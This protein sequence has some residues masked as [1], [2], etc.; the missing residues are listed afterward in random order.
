MDSHAQVVIIGAGIVGCS[1]AY[2]LSQLGCTD[3]VVVDKGPLF[4]TGG[5]STHAPGLVFQTNPSQTM[6]EL[7]RY[8]VERYGAATLDGQPCFHA[9]GGIEVAAT[10]ERWA[11]LKRKRGLASSWGV[12]SE[13]L[14]PQQVA[15][16]VPLV[17]RERIYGGFHVPGDG[18]AKPVRAA[19]AMARDAQALGVRFH[20]QVEVSG[21]DI[22][23]ERI[24]AVETDQ[25]RISCEAVV[26]CAGIWG[27]RIGRLAGVSIPVQP[28]AHQYAWTTDV[29]GLEDA[30]SEVTHP[31]L[32]HQDRAMY[33]R[34][35]QHRYGVGSYQHRSIPVSVDDIR[36]HHDSDVM[37]SVQAFTSDD[38]KRPW[39]DAQELL[40]ALT[41]SEIER[42]INGLFLFTGDGMPVLG[43]S[44]TVRG[45]WAAEAVWISHAGGAG[46]A[47]AEWLV[48]G[49]PSI[50]VR[51]ADLNRFEDFAHSPAYVRAR[52]SQNFAEVYD[53]IHPLQ[54]MEEP[55]PLRVSPFY[56]RQRELGAFFLEGAGWERPQWY[57]TNAALLDGRDI[58]G[59]DAWAERYWSPTVGAEAQVTRERV[60]L[61]D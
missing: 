22:A 46:K 1:T 48:D 47:V 49:K 50:D 18:I 9:V 32:R 61:Y 28:M 15:D 58:P 44:R 57:E 40:P 26:C 59:R 19:E 29:P 34:Q 17:D 42:G 23:D 35:H 7:A 39:L 2:H 20:G 8:T 3:V 21:F 52:A 13:L 56:A 36:S 37:P 53:I 30:E 55:R 16:L 14:S 6:T 51:Q 54:P 5:S 43:E 10:P 25:G 60:A 11:D 38:F 24:R 31:I 45:F 41:R 12:E 33:F 27:P 4:A